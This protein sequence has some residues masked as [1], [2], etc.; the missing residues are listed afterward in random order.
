MGQPVKLNNVHY[1]RISGRY[2][3]AGDLFIVG[4]MLYFFPEVDLADQR[5]KTTRY[6]PDHIALVGLAVVYLSQQVGS[7][8]SRN[9][10]EEGWSQQQFRKEADAYIG[11]IRLWLSNAQP[12]RRPH[13][14]KRNAYYSHSGGT[15]S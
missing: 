4:G 1:Y 15:S 5:E 7:Y 14:W 8:A 13:H 6:L 9:N 10:L 3:F 2:I 11:L 12:T